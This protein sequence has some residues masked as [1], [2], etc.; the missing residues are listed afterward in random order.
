MRPQ[1]DAQ[2]TVDRGRQVLVIDIATEAIELPQ[3]SDP[4]VDP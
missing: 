3:L 2:V 4:I 1:I